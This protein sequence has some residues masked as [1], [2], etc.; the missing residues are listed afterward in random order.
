MEERAPVVAEPV[1]EVPAVMPMVPEF[2]VPRADE[3]TFCSVMLPPAFMLTPPLL[4]PAPLE[5]VFRS[6]PGIVNEVPAIARKL[7]E[8]LPLP[9]EL[10]FGPSCSP[11]APLGLYMA[12][13]PPL[14]PVP[15]ESVLLLSSFEPAEL[16]LKP[17]T[18]NAK[19]ALPEA[20]ELPSDKIEP[21]LENEPCGPTR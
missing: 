15:D 5:V 19:I 21:E 9:N 12:I 14:P 20:L 2:P 6:P 17:L 10:V 13:L 1:P 11:I 7:P 16:R 18:V 4:A 8:I 3:L